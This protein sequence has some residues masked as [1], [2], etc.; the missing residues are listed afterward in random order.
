MYYV[1]ERVCKRNRNKA[2]T[3]S[4]KDCLKMKKRRKEKVEDGG[5]K[6]GYKK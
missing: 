5:E 3:R 4:E 1:C 2:C 6:K